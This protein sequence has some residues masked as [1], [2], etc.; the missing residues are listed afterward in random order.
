MQHSPSTS[1]CRP[2]PRVH[3]AFLHLRCANR[4]FWLL[5]S[6][7]TI[8]YQIEK[9]T[10]IRRY[11]YGCDTVVSDYW[12]KNKPHFLNVPLTP[13]NKSRIVPNPRVHLHSTDIYGT[14]YIDI[15][16]LYL[17]YV[18][19]CF[20]ILIKINLQT[21][22]ENNRHSFFTQLS[23]FANILDFLLETRCTTLHDL[24]RILVV[25]DKI[26]SVLHVQK[27]SIDR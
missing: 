22:S 15:P 20:E 13:W 23:P 7:Y 9:K 10:D 5:V 27:T 19:F 2:R 6:K 8:F 18:S 4:P 24:S 25:P 21:L 3:A 12:K 26:F 11:T 1:A 14:T 16:V 17:L